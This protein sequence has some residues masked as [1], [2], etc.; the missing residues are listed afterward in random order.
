ML[1]SNM[2]GYFANTNFWKDFL[3]APPDEKELEEIKQKEK[4]A[5][6]V[7]EKQL[8][9][10]EKPT[11]WEQIDEIIN[12]TFGNTKK[13][14]DNDDE[15]TSFFV[16]FTPEKFHLF[17]MDDWYKYLI[18]NTEES[19]NQKRYA[20]VM[21]KNIEAL[22][23]LIAPI[24][25]VNGLIEEMRPRNDNNTDYF[26]KKTKAAVSSDLNDRNL[27]EVL[28]KFDFLE[29][30][31][32][33]AI[34]LYIYYKKI[35]DGDAIG[36][37]KNMKNLLPYIQA[38]GSAADKM[39][40][41]VGVIYTDGDFAHWKEFKK[42]IDSYGITLPQKKKDY[43]EY[44]KKNKDDQGLKDLIKRHNLQ[45]RIIETFQQTKLAMGILVSN[46]SK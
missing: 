28:K 2:T 44:Y 46:K 19:N 25:N 36:N 7:E 17:D 33:F 29:F 10:Q 34:I 1:I 32:H 24:K 40:Y 31:R 13:Y 3:N 16:K 27:D 39:N 18:N 4:Q 38:I 45:E 30:W 35:N 6:I 21:F 41:H 15:E 43:K 42:V 11:S 20:K 23:V 8:E 5:K 22:T 26:S 12:E 37:V 9:E 14:G